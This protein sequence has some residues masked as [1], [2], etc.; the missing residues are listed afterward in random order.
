ML[1]R[2]CKEL[3]SRLDAKRRDEYPFTAAERA[4]ETAMREFLLDTESRGI[5]DPKCVW[6]ILGLLPESS[7]GRVPPALLR[8]YGMPEHGELDV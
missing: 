5:A 8:E 7:L 6:Q 3:K 4:Y 1:R 2:Q